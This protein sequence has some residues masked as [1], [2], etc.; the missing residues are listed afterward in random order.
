MTVSYE[1][2]LYASGYTKVARGFADLFYDKSPSPL[3]PAGGGTN[4]ILGPGGIVS[5]VDEVIQDG[6]GGNWGGAA[7]KLIRGYEKNKNVDLANLAQG[8]LVQAFTN[9][10]RNSSSSGSLSLGVGLNQTY[11]PYR[12][13]QT[14]AG[15]GFES[16]LQTQTTSAAGSVNSNGLNITAA[17]SAITGGIQSALSGNPIAALESNISGVITDAQGI[18]KGA[19]INKVVEVAKEAGNNLVAKVSDL[20]PTN[21]FTAGIEAANERIKSLATADTTKALQEGVGKAQAF[22]NG[23]G[24]QDAVTAFQTGTNNLVQ[25][26]DALVKTPLKN[27]QFPASSQVANNLT[28]GYFSAPPP[29]GYIGNTSTNAAGSGS[30]T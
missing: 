26:V 23:P 2:V 19:N 10:L 30:T 13:V 6:A 4:S 8:E 24:V 22:F 25:S 5:A 3:T 1:T 20:I 14:A 11:Y 12:G 7:F 18:I 27:L 29:S 15:T 16:S 28:S 17:A 9:I 21:S